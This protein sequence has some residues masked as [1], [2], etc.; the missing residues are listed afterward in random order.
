MQLTI[1]VNLSTGSIV[2]SAPEN[3]TP[4]I[5]FNFPAES[6]TVETVNR[7]INA[8]NSG[9]FKDWGWAKITIS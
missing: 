4:T 2:F 1:Y 6:F 7:L 9:V 3:I 8:S 5:D